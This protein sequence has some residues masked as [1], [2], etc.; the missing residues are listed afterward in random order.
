[1]YLQD[2]FSPEIA[3]LPGFLSSDQTT[4]GFY[5]YEPTPKG[6]LA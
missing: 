5:Q 2:I 1:M 6:Y 4:G 3:G